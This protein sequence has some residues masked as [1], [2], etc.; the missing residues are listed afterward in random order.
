MPNCRI[1]DFRQQMT[2]V[3]DVDS[4]W[5][6]PLEVWSLHKTGAIHLED[7]QTFWIEKG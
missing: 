6:H 5:L 3:D 1:S 2:D 4:S 7:T